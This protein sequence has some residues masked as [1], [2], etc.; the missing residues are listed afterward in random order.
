MNVKSMKIL[1]T[2]IFKTINNLNPSFIKDTFGSKVNLKVPPNNLIVQRYNTTQYGT[3]S[4]TTLGPHIWNNLPE[5]ILKTFC[6][7]TN[8][9]LVTVNFRNT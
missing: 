4:H 9:K 5:N 3:K 6:R 7:K 8:L 2:E 1:A